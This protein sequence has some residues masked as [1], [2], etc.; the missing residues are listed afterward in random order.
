PEQAAGEA[1]TAASDVYA[2]G[3]ILF[4]MLTGRL[5]FE[6]PDALT[7]AAMHR[8]QP[9]PP[10]AAFR[11]DAP[12]RLESL[13]TACLA[14]SPADRPPNGAALLAELGAP[15]PAAPVAE[16]AA[17]TQVLAPPTPTA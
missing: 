2:F 14:K 7:L 1:A 10:V 3:V 15:A 13:A 11:E 8:D 4:R 5:P 12:S 6:S 9:P 17:M 16:T